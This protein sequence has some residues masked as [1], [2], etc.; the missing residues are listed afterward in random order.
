MKYLQF[1]KNIVDLYLSYSRQKRLYMLLSTA[2]ASVGLIGGLV[3]YITDSADLIIQNIRQIQRLK[4]EN[5][6]LVERYEKAQEQEQK[7][8]EQ[9]NQRKDMSIKT[10]FEKF[11]KEQNLSPEG[12]WAETEKNPILDNDLF[13]E[14]IL[15]ASFKS[16][17]AEAIV[18]ILEAIDKEN[19]VEVSSVVLKKQDSLILL[20][21]VLAMKRFKKVVEEA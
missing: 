8:I 17:T 20:D 4:T 9:V 12:N 2:A 21:L 19:I 16:M 7:F 6:L 13:E 3:W 10:Y 11:I 5:V 18:K 1:I 14:E 15:R